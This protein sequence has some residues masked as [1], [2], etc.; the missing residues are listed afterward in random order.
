MAS[1]SELPSARPVPAWRARLVSFWRWWTGELRKVAYERFAALRGMGEVPTVSLEASALA[2]L[3]P[4][5]PD[6]AE[7]RID[8]AGL[9]PA[10][11]QAALRTLLERVG[12]SRG[13]V[14][15]ALSPQE[16][17]V[18]RVTMPAAT[19]ENLAQVLAFEMDRLTPF[20]AEDVYFDYRIVGRDAAAGQLALQL[21]V[22][23]RERVDG[24]V[25]RLRALG[26]S[27]QGVVVREGLGGPA[28]ALD[29]LPSEQRGERESV[30]ER[31]VQRSLVAAVVI[32]FALALLIPLWRKR[33]TVIA[34]LPL[35]AKAQQ[36][37][38]ATDR[39]GRDVERQVEDY[40]FLLAKKLSAYPVLAYLEEVSR[41][42]P[43]NTWLQQMQYKLNGKTH[44][45]QMTGETASSSKLIE[46]LT[47]SKLLRNP[48]PRG[49]TTRGSTP[50]SERFTIGVEAMAR[51]LPETVP[52]L[53]SAPPPAA[54]RAATPAAPP[55]T[56]AQP[57]PAQRQPAPQ[58]A[59]AP[60]GA[61]PQP[62]SKPAASASSA[63]WAAQRHPAPPAGP[64]K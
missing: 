51:P 16:A 53:S 15:L 37:A 12:E 6:G 41:L 28:G 45:L 3:R 27:V 34:L 9:E 39:I 40:N 22:A 17:L 29:L 19:E 4:L 55:A 46:V 14:Q 42:L 10:R 35:V 52:I 58:G 43:D 63:A 64:P 11:A 48:T 2:V 31:L 23:R 18:R 50:N 56:P 44:E 38:Q 59:T 62:A 8:L 54:P 49:T 25:A 36:E 20:R 21:A 33:E 7:A 32:L 61:R 47:S 1:A 60:P 26:A 5:P 24:F 13:R 57:A 30:N